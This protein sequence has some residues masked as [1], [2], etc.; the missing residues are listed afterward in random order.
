MTGWS[1]LFSIAFDAKSAQLM[2]VMIVLVSILFSG[3]SPRLAAI[4]AMGPS[5]AVPAHMSY[6]RW[7]MEDLYTSETAT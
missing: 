2:I 7:L 4:A 6:A 5:G 1:Y 3:L